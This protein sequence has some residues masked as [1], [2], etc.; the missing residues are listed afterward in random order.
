M[1][2]YARPPTGTIDPWRRGSRC[3]KSISRSPAA[4]IA[5]T[6]PTFIGTNR[7]SLLSEHSGM[8][9]PTPISRHRGGRGARRRGSLSRLQ[10]FEHAAGNAQIG[11]AEAFS[12][13]LI[14]RGQDLS[15]LAGAAL[16]HTQSRKAERGPQFP[17]QRVLLP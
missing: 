2:S 9:Q 8:F 15:C 1:I 5:R 14:D 7:D 17:K 16:P 6:T 10:R 13:A 4:W 3:T 11:S 12:K